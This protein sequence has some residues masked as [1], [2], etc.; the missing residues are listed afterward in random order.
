MIRDVGSS[1]PCE[2][3]LVLG[4]FGLRRQ[5]WVTTALGD[6]ALLRLSPRCGDQSLFVVRDA[7]PAVSGG[8]V[9]KSGASKSRK[10]S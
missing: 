4:R 8:I 5:R 6:V 10:W 1:R 9:S 7:A 3:K 2:R